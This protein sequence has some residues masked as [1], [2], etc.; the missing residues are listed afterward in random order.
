MTFSAGQAV[1]IVVRGRWKRYVVTEALTRG[2][3]QTVRMHAK[4]DG[5]TLSVSASRLRNW[6]ENGSARLVP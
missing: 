1:E 6:I 4:R 2:R 3:G 5:S